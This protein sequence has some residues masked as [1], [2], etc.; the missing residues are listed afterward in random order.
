MAYRERYTDALWETRAFPGAAEAA[1]AIAEQRPVAI[2]TSKPLRHAEPVLEAI[3]LRDLFGVIAAPVPDGP[4]DKLAM[5]TQAIASVGDA[6][7][8]VGDRRYDIE[9]GRALGLHTIGV[10]WGYG[11]DAELRTAGAHTLLE[12]PAELTAAC[13]A[14]S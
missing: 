14:V 9:A 3:G 5:V 1:R 11:S 4:A 8:M 2:A 12:T 13:L 6:A 10:L 7:V